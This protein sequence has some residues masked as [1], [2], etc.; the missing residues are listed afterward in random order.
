M[1]RKQIR[2]VKEFKDQRN[3]IRSTQ[4]E[5]IAYTTPTSIVGKT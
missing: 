3:G 1:R 2:K 4:R 5:G